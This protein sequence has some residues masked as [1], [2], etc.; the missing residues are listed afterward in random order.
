MYAKRIQHLVSEA[1]DGL[2]QLQKG[3]EDLEEHRKAKA[4]QIVETALETAG[5]ALVSS[6]ESPPRIPLEYKKQ[7]EVAQ[8]NQRNWQTSLAKAIKEGKLT[9][10]GHKTL[11]PVKVLGQN[12]LEV[13]S[14][15]DA[16]KQKA[17]TLQFIDGVLRCHL[18]QAT[19]Q[20]QRPQKQAQA[21]KASQPLPT[22]PSTS[23]P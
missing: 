15:A 4:L 18:V 1:A 11:L 23:S 13:R 12:K 17:L 10:I 8:N 20:G 6:L 5:G 22:G 3:W 16:L 14:A 2:A 19:G 7:Q 9:F 21:K